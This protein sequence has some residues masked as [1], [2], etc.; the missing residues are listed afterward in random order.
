MSKEA[1]DWLTILK[2]HAKKTFKSI[3]IRPRKIKPSEA[4]KLITHRNRLV[5]EHKVKDAQQLNVNIATIV[6]K[7]SG[8]KAFMPTWKKQT[9]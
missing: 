6:A 9:Q 5:I 1:E 3:R 2:T 4:D 8:K 7:E